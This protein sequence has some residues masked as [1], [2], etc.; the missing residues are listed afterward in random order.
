MCIFNTCPLFIYM[1]FSTENFDNKKFSKQCT[2]CCFNVS[3]SYNIVCLYVILICNQICI[4]QLY[5]IDFE[6]LM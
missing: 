6:K 4:K 2:F 5:G 3:K 1:V